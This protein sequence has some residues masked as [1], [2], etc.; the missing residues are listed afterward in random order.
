[1]RHAAKGLVTL[2]TWPADDATT[3]PDVAQLAM[4]RL[5]WLQTLLFN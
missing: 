5:L 4:L 1:V 2:Q 3:G